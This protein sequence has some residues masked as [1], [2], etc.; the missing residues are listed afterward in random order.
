MKIQSDKSIKIFNQVKIIFF[1]K[2]NSKFFEKLCLELFKS[3]FDKKIVW[4]FYSKNVPL[5]NFTESVVKEANGSE[6]FFILFSDELTKVQLN[7]LKQIFFIHGKKILIFS[8][9][10]YSEKFKEFI[11]YEKIKKLEVKSIKNKI[12]KVIKKI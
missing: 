4:Y 2:N 10:K 11:F 9:K 3:Y 6:T 7:Y 12:I 8:D 1:D 5:E